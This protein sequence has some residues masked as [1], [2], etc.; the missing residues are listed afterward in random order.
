MVKVAAIHYGVPA[1][2]EKPKYFS[3]V[4]NLLVA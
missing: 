2:Y 4:E 3:I 1:R